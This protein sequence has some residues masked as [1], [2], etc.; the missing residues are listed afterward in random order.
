MFRSMEKNVPIFNNA[1][2]R[3]MIEPKTFFTA[4]KIPV[5]DDAKLAASVS[6]P[7]LKSLKPLIRTKI[8]AAIQPIGVSNIIFASPKKALP[9][10]TVPLK[11]PTLAVPA[12]FFATPSAK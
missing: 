12:A 9:K 5:N 2:K 8:P 6:F 7:S 4:S 10:S 3:S 1:L 11:R